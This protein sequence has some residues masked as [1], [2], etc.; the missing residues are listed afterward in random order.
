MRKIGNERWRA[1]GSSDMVCILVHLLN[2]HVLLPPLGRADRF[3][4]PLWWMSVKFHSM[5]G[6]G[7]TALRVFSYTKD[8]TQLSAATEACVVQQPPTSVH[9][10]KKIIYFYVSERFACVHNCTNVCA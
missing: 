7:L 6:K 2:H 1:E 3:T 5:I 10:L 9:A 4:K 8:S